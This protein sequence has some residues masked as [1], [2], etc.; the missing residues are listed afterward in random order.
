MYKCGWAGLSGGGIECLWYLARHSLVNRLIRVNYQSLKDSLE[1][2]VSTLTGGGDRLIRPSPVRVFI[3]QIQ[4]T[5]PISVGQMCAARRQRT[6][7]PKYT[8]TWE[9]GGSVSGSTDIRSGDRRDDVCLLKWRNY[10]TRRQFS[11][12]SSIEMERER[13]REKERE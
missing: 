1:Q 5:Q 6:N 3:V 10:G 9:Q 2:S 4:T 8:Q 13:E 7:T 11:D 12:D